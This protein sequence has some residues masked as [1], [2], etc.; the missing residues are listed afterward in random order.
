MAKHYYCSVC[1]IELVY[2]RKAV[3]KKGLVLDLIQPHECEGYSVRSNVDEKPTVEDVLRDTKDVQKIVEKE[4]EGTGFFRRN[5]NSNLSDKREEVRTSTAP[6]SL[7]ENI[8]GMQ[9]LESE[10]ELED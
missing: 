6:R 4:V 7:L 9:N 8:H 2:S 5:F 1:G 10:D 3:P